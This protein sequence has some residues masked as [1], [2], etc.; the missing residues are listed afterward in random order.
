M[1]IAKTYGASRDAPLRSWLAFRCLAEI[2]VV[3][4]HEAPRAGDMAF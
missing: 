4:N 3:A 1:V 2:C